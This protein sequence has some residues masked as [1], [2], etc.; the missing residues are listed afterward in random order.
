MAIL[1]KGRQEMGTAVVNV[2]GWIEVII[3]VT[4]VFSGEFINFHYL[5][6]KFM[7]TYYYGTMTKVY[8]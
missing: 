8:D 4:I 1:G 3:A 2:I 7:N 5:I 6:I